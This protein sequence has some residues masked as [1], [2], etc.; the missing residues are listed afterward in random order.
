M[1][2]WV[3]GINLFFLLFRVLYVLYYPIDL[4]P[5]EA[6]Y[7]D[8]SRHLD[9]SYYS[10]PPMVA[11][12]NA[13]STAILGDTEL[14]V[15]INAIL[16]SFFLSLITYV[17]VRKLFDEKVAFI[18]STF[19]NLFVGFSLNSVLFTTDSPLLFFWALSAISV[20]EASKKSTPARWALV[21]LFG[22]LAFL[23]KYSAVLLLPCALLYLSL[24]RRELLLRREVYVSLP[25]AF[26]LSLPVLVWN[27]KTGFLSFRHVSGLATKDGGG[28]NLSYA[29]EFLG[30]QALLLSGLPFLFILFGWAMS[31][32]L[33]EERLLFLTSFSLPVFLFFLLL[34]FKTR[35]YANWAGF[36]YYTAGILFS[37]LFV[38]SPFYLKLPTLLF[39]SFL[40]LVMHFTPLLDLMGLGK[41]LPPEKDPTKFLVGW[42]KLGKEVSKHYTGKELIFSTS[43]QISA[44]LAFYVE[45][46]PRTYVF[47][48]G[49]YTQ[50]YLWREGLKRFKGKDAIFVNYGGI[51]KEVLGSFT[52]S[53]LL[54]SVRVVWRGKEVRRF[55][56]Y[57]L[58]GF[59]GWFDERPERY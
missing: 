30:G 54:G 46:K 9:L 28:V 55:N 22:G 27:V 58:E 23:S 48:I 12:M 19:P 3:L 34:S 40:V 4:S 25:V 57:K 15:R 53:Y 29:L 41:L 38:R 10:K 42:E 51:P 2:K 56:V 37:Y 50:Y 32:R 7:W 36:G 45:G 1:L 31:L 47:H 17:F 24:T 44:E 43:Y 11:Y 52:S 14:G 6:Q 16:L 8:W 39:A 26:L 59:K 35:V 20:Y 33:R 5:E 49:R 13:L 21:G 18:A